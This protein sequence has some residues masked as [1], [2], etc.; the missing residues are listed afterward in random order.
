MVMTPECP[1]YEVGILVYDANEFY[2]DF[3]R[4]GPKESI[5]EK[6]IARTLVCQ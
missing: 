1:G 2:T 3:I 6:R 4:T 5:L